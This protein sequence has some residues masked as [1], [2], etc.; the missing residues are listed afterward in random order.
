MCI[1]WQKPNIRFVK[2]KMFVLPN[3]RATPPNHGRTNIENPLFNHNTVIRIENNIP[4]TFQ[5]ITT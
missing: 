1:E 5:Q 4:L 3:K 2:H